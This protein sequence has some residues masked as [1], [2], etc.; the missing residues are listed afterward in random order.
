MIGFLC[1]I[2]LLSLLGVSTMV[3]PALAASEAYLVGTV[4]DLTDAPVADAEVFI[5][6]STNVRRPADFISPKT[7]AHGAY[8]LQL[9][10]GTYWAVARVRKGERFGPLALDYR[11]SGEPVQVFVGDAP[12]VRLDFTVADL[13]EEA[14]RRNKSLSEL[15]PVRGRIVDA[16]GKGVAHAYVFA[17]KVAPTVAIPAFISP[18][19]DESGNFTLQLPPGEFDLGATREFPPSAKPHQMRH[20]RVEKDKLPVAIDLTLLLE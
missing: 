2:F 18:W 7:D 3:W 20:L 13:R 9:P 8:R 17:A 19:S 5:Y 14:Q 16:S 11:H 1:R 15:I 12:E 6:S 10:A 4:R